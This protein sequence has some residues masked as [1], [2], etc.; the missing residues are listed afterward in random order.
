M[1]WEA[2]GALGEIISALV[3]AITLAYFD[4][5]LRSSREAASD[6]NRLERV[7]SRPV[8]VWYNGDPRL[9]WWS[10]APLPSPFG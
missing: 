3:V 8:S 2:I 9:G 10:F 7:H 4:I 6:A 5:Q 1:N